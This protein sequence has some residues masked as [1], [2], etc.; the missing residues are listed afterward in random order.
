MIKGRRGEGKPERKILQGEHQE[1]DCQAE[2]GTV[3][4]KICTTP[5]RR[6][7]HLWDRQAEARAEFADKSVAKLQKEVNTEKL[8]WYG[9]DIS[10]SVRDPDYEKHLFS[11]AKSF[12]GSIE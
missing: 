10:S 4:L 11:T 1:P 3:C 5:A 8:F 6:F 12:E 7:S 2:A 9:S